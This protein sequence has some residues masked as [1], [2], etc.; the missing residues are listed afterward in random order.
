MIYVN[1]KNDN[2]VGYMAI[3]R[4]P[5]ENNKYAFFNITKNILKPCRFNSEEEAFADNTN[6][7]KTEKLKNL[8]Y[9]VSKIMYMIK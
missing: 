7:L 4:L 9:K 6:I 2:T 8:L 3:V 5:E 1:I